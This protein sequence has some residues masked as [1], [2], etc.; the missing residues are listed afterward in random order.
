MLVL[1]KRLVSAPKPGTAVI[2]FYILD[3]GEP[4]EPVHIS[5]CGGH[6]LKENVDL[7][8]VSPAIQN[9]VPNDEIP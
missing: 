3:A 4:L 8:S 6:G 1:Q 2:Y 7:T 9:K 5:D